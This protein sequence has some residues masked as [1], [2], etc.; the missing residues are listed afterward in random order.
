MHKG[1]MDFRMSWEQCGRKREKALLRSGSQSSHRN[2]KALSLPKLFSS[3][4]MWKES[5]V[6]LSCLELYLTSSDHVCGFHVNGVNII[7][8]QGNCASGG[9]NP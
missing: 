6:T 2:H 3:C 8:F 5:V 1:Y 4:T 7:K 9:G